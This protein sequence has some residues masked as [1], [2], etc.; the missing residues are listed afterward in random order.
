MLSISAISSRKTKMPRP[1]SR[2]ATLA[3]AA[4]TALLSSTAV[5]FAQNTNSI[6][7][8]VMNGQSGVYADIT[9]P[10]S[11]AAARLAMEDAGGSVLGRPIELLV[12]D[13]QNKPDT[14]AALAREWF[15]TRG[16]SAIFDIYH[17]GVALAVQKLAGD[18]NKLLVVSMASSGLIS[19]KQ[20]SPNGMQWANDGYQVSNLTVKSAEG[21]GPASWFFL[22]VDYA[23]GHSIEKDAARMI[24]AGGGKVLGSVRFPIGTPDF[25]SFLLQ[26]Q[27]SGAKNIGF[28]GGGADLTNSMKQ[29]DEFNIR[30]AGQKFI[31]FSL[32]TVD[33]T[34]VGSKV[35]AGMPVV[36]SYYWGENEATLQWAERFKKLTGKLPTD[37]QANI[38]SAVS[39]YLKSVKAAGSDDT[40]AVL[41]KMRDTPVDDFF[42]RGARIRADGRLM[43]DIIIAEAKAPDEMKNP[44]DLLKIVSRI[45]G[46]Q[47]FTPVAESECPLL[48]K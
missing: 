44:D 20:C 19:G 48:K 41:A 45:S 33:I 36:L 2:A 11:V 16:V 38:Y 29:A 28:I 37:P 1:A 12:A 39:H 27:A 3:L 6:K 32:T 43:R 31:P 21:S 35:T 15:D 26:A 14:G 7:I 46:E 13:H 4:V 34:G 23:A 25:S 18:K 47:A 8:G 9:G 5:G 10:G 22:T 42:T 17:S 30:K 24:Q 40:A